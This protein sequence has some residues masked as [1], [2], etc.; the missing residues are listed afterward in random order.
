MITGRYIR[1]RGIVSKKIIF[2]DNDGVLVDTERLYF[3]ATRQVLRPFG[4][5]LAEKQ[6]HQFFLRESRGAWHLAV[7]KGFPAE[8]V[9]G[10]REARNM[11]HEEMIGKEDLRRPDVA[12]LL[13]SLAGSVRMGVVTSSW[14]RHFEA[15]HARTG[16][17]KYFEFVV[18]GDDVTETKP[19]PEPY[20]MALRRAGCEASECVAVEDSE[21]GLIAAK[22]AGLECWVIPSDLTRHGD[23]SRADKI[24]GSISEVAAELGVKLR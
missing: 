13:M 24:L 22:A 4:V 18:T 9:G 23:F 17:D 10:L 8:E 15:I 21:R 7:E 16:F 12:Q 5:E 11:V 6:F 19:D 2:W 1:G 14:R 3:I 20:V